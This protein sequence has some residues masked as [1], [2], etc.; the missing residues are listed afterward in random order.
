MAKKRM[1]DLDKMASNSIQMSVAA[2]NAKNVTE[3][4]EILSML[5]GQIKRCMEY[6]QKY[7]G[8]PSYKQIKQIKDRLE[9]RMLN[10]L[11]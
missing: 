1:K 10:L 4:K 3:P 2:M 6:F 11:K 7:P 8:G 9:I 5:K